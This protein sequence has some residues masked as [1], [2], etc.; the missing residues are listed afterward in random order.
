MYNHD[1]VD[2]DREQITGKIVN[3]CEFGMKEL[4]G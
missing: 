3:V 1:K 2:S 4:G